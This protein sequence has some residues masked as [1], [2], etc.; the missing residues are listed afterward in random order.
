MSV[1]IALL[2][3]ISFLSSQN[4][5]DGQRQIVGGAFSIMWFILVPLIFGIVSICK[6]LYLLIY[7][8]V[9]ENYLG[10]A[11]LTLLVSATTIV[12][13]KNKIKKDRQ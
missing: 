1:A 5:I 11:V 10:I 13:M 6:N 4:D 12:L 7:P 8:Q 3:R 9:M 2:P